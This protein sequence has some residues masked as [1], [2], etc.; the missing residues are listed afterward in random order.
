MIERIENADDS[1]YRPLP[2]EVE[3]RKSE[4]EGTGLFAKEDIEKGHVLG[5][6]HLYLDSKIIRTPLGGFYN[7]SDSP[8]CIKQKQNYRD[9]PGSYYYLVSLRDISKEEEI[10]VDYTFYNIED[11]KL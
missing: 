11:M 8:N 10:T 4:I 1:N 5:M 6:T 2:K 7:H 3:L 9:T